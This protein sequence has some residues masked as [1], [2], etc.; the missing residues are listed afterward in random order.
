MASASLNP[1]RGPVD[2]ELLTGPATY[3]IYVTGPGGVGV[4]CGEIVVGAPT[5]FAD[6]RGSDF[7]FRLI[8]RVNEE[9]APR[10]CPTTL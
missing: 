7:T 3:V 5:K 8:L 4:A 6:G 10:S 2:D 1:P 9:N